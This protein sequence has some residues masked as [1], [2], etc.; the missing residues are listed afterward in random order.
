MGSLPGKFSPF[1]A[2]LSLAALAVFSNPASSQSLMASSNYSGQ[3]AAIS[4]LRVGSHPDK[5]RIVLDVSQPTDLSYKVSNDGRTIRLELPKASWQ[6]NGSQSRYTGGSIIGFKHNTG[7]QGST[8]TLQ[9]DKAIRI[10]RP[11]FVSPGENRG[12]RIV[13][14]MVPAPVRIAKKTNTSFVASLDNIGALPQQRIEV[15]QATGSRNPYIQRAFPQGNSRTQPMPRQVAPQPVRTQKAPQMQT[16]HQVPRQ[17]M[18]T[19]QRK[20]FMG[21]S[22]TY[23]R[24]SLGLHMINET[25]SEGGNSVYDA[26]FDPGFMISG[27]LGTKLDNGFRVEGEFFYSNASLKQVSG[28]ID[29]TTY[30]SENVTGDLT[31]FA[32]MGNVAY[33][34]PNSSRLTPYFMGGLGLAALNLNDFQVSNTSVADDMDWVFAMQLGA[35]VTFDLDNRTKIEVGYRY[36]ET[37]DPEFS[38][39]TG[40]P[41]ESVFSSHTFLVGARVDLN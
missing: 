11:F 15:A 38:D 10:K 18:P 8:L 1:A 17:A 9:T 20:G 16:P 32:F 37:Q 7:V 30:N 40:T 39:K 33:D 25:S 24:G 19:Q 3:A 28:T 34:I 4:N 26:E 27:A 5:T 2:I 29:S 14:D 21:L 12:H 13:I 31:T 6:A 36:F 22:N 41:F 23:A 35:G